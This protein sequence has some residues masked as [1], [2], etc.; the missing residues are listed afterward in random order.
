MC[1]QPPPPAHDQPVELSSSCH[2]A[3]ISEFFVAITVMV[4]VSMAIKA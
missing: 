1:H 4:L 3:E 2:S